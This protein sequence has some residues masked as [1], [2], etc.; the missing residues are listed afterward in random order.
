MIDVED[1]VLDFFEL[2]VEVEVEEWRCVDYYAQD[3]EDFC[4]CDVG[5]DWLIAL[6]GLRLLGDFL[7]VEAEDET[8]DH[9]F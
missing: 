4:Y 3:E 5:I 9:W 7:G 8:E 2:F 6:L 1:V